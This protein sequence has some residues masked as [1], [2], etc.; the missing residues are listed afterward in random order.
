MGPQRIFVI[1]F[2]FSTAS[3]A[4]AATPKEI[5]CWKLLT[6]GSPKIRR[7]AE[8]ILNTE[9][10]NQN[11]TE[12]IGNGLM[13]LRDTDYFRPRLEFLQRNG[14][15]TLN[16]VK[17]N[18]FTNLGKYE[19][20]VPMTF[21][22][23]DQKYY[24][25][26][27]K[28]LDELRSVKSADLKK[29]AA[30]G[31]ESKRAEPPP[32]QPTQPTQP[33][34]AL[35][36]TTLPSLRPTRQPPPVK[37]WWFPVREFTVGKKFQLCAS[38]SKTHLSAER[39]VGIVTFFNRPGWAVFDYDFLRMSG[40][41]GLTT[42]LKRE[43]GINH[44]DDQIIRQ[45]LSLI[46]A[47]P[48]QVDTVSALRLRGEG[49]KARMDDLVRDQKI[50]VTE[51]P[52]ET[53]KR[54]VIIPLMSLQD[55]DPRAKSQMEYLDKPETDRSWKDDNEKPLP[56]P[57]KD[58]SKDIYLE[59]APP[60]K[61]MVVSFGPDA[62]WHRFLPNQSYFDRQM[63]IN[64]HLAIP[65]NWKE[66]E[67]ELPLIWFDQN[68]EV[69]IASVIF[70]FSRQENGDVFL[71]IQSI[72]ELNED[73]QRDYFQKFARFHRI[74]NST[75]TY[76]RERG[77][78]VGTFK[79]NELILPGYVQAKIMMKHRL[80]MPDIRNIL[81][82]LIGASRIDRGAFLAKVEYGAYLYDVIIKKTENNNF[83]I[84]SMYVRGGDD[85]W[86]YIQQSLGF[87]GYAP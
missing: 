27:A 19:S 17:L 50:M 7:Q 51:F 55:S 15:L 72:Q 22:I 10:K 79:T 48:E 60:I 20:K 52:D 32:T 45:V 68:H 5:D 58:P 59:K 25:I 36:V 70:L 64:L 46:A 43:T 54:I 57:V 77:I 37:V 78:H 30:E 13:L 63:W 75:F 33:E 16:Q 9:L 76:P 87:M 1:L 67:Y 38:G 73:F 21:I 4:F 62:K 2:I 18:S 26:H 29:A 86:S 53:K 85:A 61:S 74:A 44:V 49:G 81:S 65:V 80:E 35:P 83:V 24:V 39:P 34:P 40:I 71:N 47:P 82:R 31:K 42:I 69:R 14:R 12:K 23:G 3:T 8:D 28:T 6:D 11:F 66:G 41:D 84:L 56:P